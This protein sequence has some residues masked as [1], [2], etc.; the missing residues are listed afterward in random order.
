MICMNMLHAQVIIWYMCVH[1]MEVDS[2]HAVWQQRLCMYRHGCVDCAAVQL[3]SSA[4]ASR[5]YQIVQKHLRNSE[6]S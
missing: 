6:S 5:L 4:A 2:R 1:M 3:G